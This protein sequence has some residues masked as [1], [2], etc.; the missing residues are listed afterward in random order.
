MS[1]LFSSPKVAPP[2]PP[3]VMPTPDD[4]ASVMAKRRQM[5]A[6]QVRSGRQSTIM[7]QNKDSFGG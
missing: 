6:A 4:Q 1:G 3:V 7:T 2:P 5:G